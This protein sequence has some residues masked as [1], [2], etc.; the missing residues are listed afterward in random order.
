[1][2]FIGKVKNKVFPSKQAKRV[3]PWFKA[4]G[5]KTLRLD[6]DLNEQS[7]VFDLGGYEGQWASDIFSKY[8]CPVFIFEPY[9]KYAEKISERFRHNT[10]IKVFAFGLGKINEHLTL[11]ESDDASSVYKKK[12]TAYTIELKKASSFILEQGITKIDLMKINIEGGE[13]DLL[14]ELLDENMVKRIVNLQIQFHD[15]VERS[16]ERMKKIQERLSA[17]H[18]LSYQFEYVWENWVLKK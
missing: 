8:V 9:I 16:D 5:D 13:Y 18:Q 11:Y 17:T 2:S 7:T 6:Y 10:K 14:E 1:M 3:K 4:N 15:F 12:G